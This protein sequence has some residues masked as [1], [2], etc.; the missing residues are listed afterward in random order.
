LP[1]FVHCREFLNADLIAAGLAS[2]APETQ[3]VRAGRLLLERIREL[4]SQR[5]NFGFETTRSIRPNLRQD[6]RRDEGQP[7]PGAAVF[8]TLLAEHHR[9]ALRILNHGIHRHARK[10]KDGPHKFACSYLFRALPRFP[11][12]DFLVFKAVVAGRSAEIVDR[13]PPEISGVRRE[14]SFFLRL[15]SAEI[16]VARVAN[17]V[18]QGAAREG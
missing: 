12:L 10:V 14:V 13:P 7:L 11:W 18:K 15:S 3:N 17:R 9:V 2:F 1:D 16:T 8:S 6:P 4:A 5:A